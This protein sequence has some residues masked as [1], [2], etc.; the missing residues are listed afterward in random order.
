[1]LELKERFVLDSHGNRVGVQLDMADY[2]RVLDALE[3]LE[4]LRAFDEAVAV[5]D[6]AIPFEQAV[7]EIKRKR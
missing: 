6:R 4:S 7:A 5:R 1:M 3:E 2:Q